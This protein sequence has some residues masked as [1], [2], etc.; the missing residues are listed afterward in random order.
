MFLSGEF[1][2]SSEKHKSYFHLLE[3]SPGKN[4]DLNILPA[5]KTKMFSIIGVDFKTFIESHKRQNKQWLCSEMLI[6]KV[7]GDKSSVTLRL[8]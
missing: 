8:S 6:L 3:K 5:N 1:Y 4:S 2:F 7:R